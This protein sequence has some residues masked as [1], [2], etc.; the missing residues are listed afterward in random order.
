M[1]QQ[2]SY[3]LGSLGLIPFIAIILLCVISPPDSKV[4]SLLIFIYIA[5]AAV[6]SSF[7]A[8]IQWGLITSFAD[9]IY[10]VF[11]PLLITV[12]P[13]LISW[14]ALLSLENLKLSLV[15]LLISYVI[16]L[17]HDYY[18]YQQLKITPRWFIKM[19]VILS[20]TVSMLTIILIIFV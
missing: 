19:K 16:S 10:Y 15:L 11:T 7:L 5:Y 3:I 12:I 18:L 14:A 13:A 1:G 2:Q 6:I 17:L 8:G 4:Y 9:K 20:L